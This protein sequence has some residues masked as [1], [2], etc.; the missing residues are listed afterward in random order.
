[1]AWH[2]RKTLV[3]VAKGTKKLTAVNKV[4]LLRRTG[5]NQSLH[6]CYYIRRTT[7]KARSPFI[8][9]KYKVPLVRVRNMIRT[10]NIWHI[11][12][13]KS[14]TIKFLM[15]HAKHHKA[16]K[17]VKNSINKITLTQILTVIYCYNSL[18]SA[19]L[20]MGQNHVGT[21]LDGASN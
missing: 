6:Y 21:H 19:G 17:S 5:W 10:C 15:S 18:I 3:H 4:Y 11:Q 7:S 8:I 12:K 1:M 9:L 2:W 20:N 13:Y 16:S 14:F